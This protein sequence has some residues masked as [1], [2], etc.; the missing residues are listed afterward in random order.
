M[1]LNEFKSAE[2]DEFHPAVRRDPAEGILEPLAITFM[3]RCEMS[4]VVEDWKQANVMPL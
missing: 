1:H 4:E 2:P 3:K